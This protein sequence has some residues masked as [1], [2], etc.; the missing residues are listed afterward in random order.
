[1]D[2]ELTSGVTPGFGLFFG[3]ERQRDFVRPRRA[4]G[5]DFKVIVGWW[6][7]NLSVQWREPAQ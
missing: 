3:W 4:Y 2:F 5:V 1:M 6:V 7:A